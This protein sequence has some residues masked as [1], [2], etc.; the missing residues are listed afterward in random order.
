[1]ESIEINLSLR[2]ILS[3]QYNDPTYGNTPFVI[4]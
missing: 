1:M 3:G 4:S 2:K